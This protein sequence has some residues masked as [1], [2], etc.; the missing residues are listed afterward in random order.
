MVDCTC[1]LPRRHRN[2]YLCCATWDTQ[3]PSVESY[4]EG[5]AFAKEQR[6]GSDRP[7]LVHCAHGHGRS[8]AMLCAILISEGKASSIDEAQAMIKKIRPRVGLNANQR[9]GLERWFSQRC[10]RV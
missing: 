1:E 4:E 8:A 6:R 7:V 10:K 2:P 5:V 9:E 3:S